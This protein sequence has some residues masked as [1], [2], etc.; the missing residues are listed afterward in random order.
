LSL[1]I[2]WRRFFT[3]NGYTTIPPKVV[4]IWTNDRLKVPLWLDRGKQRI[5]R[6]DSW[7]HCQHLDK[8]TPEHWKKRARKRGGREDTLFKRDNEESTQ[9]KCTKEWRN[10]LK[11]QT[12]QR[13]RYEI[14]DARDTWYL[15]VTTAALVTLVK[16]KIHPQ[17]RHRGG[18]EVQA[19]YSFFNLDDRRSGWTTLPALLPRKRADTHCTGSWV[20][21]RAGLDGCGKSRPPLGSDPRNVQPVASRYTD[22]AIPAHIGNIGG[23]DK[24]CNNNQEVIKVRRSLCEMS[25]KRVRF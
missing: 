11:K 13:G 25:V 15:R 4:G 16:G 14:W 3:C 19:G 21:P 10:K 7:W 24:Q 6:Y 18:A 1:P 8:R 20:G 22:W 5:L 2:I 17:N 9:P 23:N 12:K